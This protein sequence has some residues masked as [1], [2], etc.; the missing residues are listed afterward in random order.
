MAHG[1][2]L[3]V[4]TIGKAHGIRGELKVRCS[5]EHYHLL[6][7][8]PEVH[9]DGRAMRVQQIRGHVS[10][11]ILQL[12]G[13]TS[14]TQAEQLQGKS[15]SVHRDLLPALEDDEYYVGDLEGLEAWS[16]T[17][18]IGVVTQV[19]VLPANTVLTVAR[20]AGSTLLVP[21]IRDAVP[22]MDVPGGRIEL[23]ME[24]LGDD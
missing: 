1:S 9:V 7:T 17:Q 12:V 13:V 11:P 10:S 8:G 19:D 20:D 23:N 3:T 21:L 24:F 18:R 22:V 6:A 14:R 15:I 4:A 5:E 2:L 16:G